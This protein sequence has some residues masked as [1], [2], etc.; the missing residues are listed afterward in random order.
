MGI[1][2]VEIHT[3]DN[4]VAKF[5]KY[6]AKAMFPMYSQYIGISDSN[7]E[8]HDSK[9][10][11]RFEAGTSKPILTKGILSSKNLIYRGNGTFHKPS[12]RPSSCLSSRVFS[13]SITET[14]HCVF[15]I[16]HFTALILD[17][18]LALLQ[19]D[20]AQQSVYMLNFLSW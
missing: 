18:L 17:C 5:E 15:L 10:N 20:C 3:L 9:A 2:G 14:W 11:G 8:N 12:M 13:Q 16:D 4:K 19:L 1:L 7:S 6:G